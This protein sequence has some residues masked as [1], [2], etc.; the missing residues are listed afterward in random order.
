VTHTFSQPG[1][2]V[3]TLTARNAQGAPDLTPERLH[4]AVWEGEFRDD[5]N[6]ASLDVEEHGWVPPL[7]PEMTEWVIDE[8]WLNVTRGAEVPGITA[9]TTWVSAQ[10]AH[11]EVTQRRSAANVEEHYTDVLCR[12]HPTDFPNRYYRVRIWEIP[13]TFH[14]PTGNCVSIN[15]YKMSPERGNIGEAAWPELSRRHL[16]CGWP[17]DRNFRVVVDLVGRRF[18]VALEDPERPGRP[19]LEVSW[20]DTQEDAFLWVGRFGLTEY[21][22]QSW[23]D[24]F[25]IREL[26]GTA[27]DA[28]TTP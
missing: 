6:R 26:P 23:F 12:V 28:G 25:S 4:V 13:N 16:T 19:V 18:D 22:G 2:H 5:F 17:R 24:D 15:I 7:E 11:I 14:A 20:T 9:L 21:Q 8:G 3:V 10:N 1:F 27:A